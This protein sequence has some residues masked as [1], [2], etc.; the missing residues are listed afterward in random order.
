MDLLSRRSFLGTATALASASLVSGRVQAAGIPEAPT[1][2][3][4]ATQPPRHPSS[5]PEYRPV[6]TLNGWSLPWRM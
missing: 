2:D 1:M 3:K 6:V 4:V 5:G